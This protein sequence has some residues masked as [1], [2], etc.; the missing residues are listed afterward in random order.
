MQARPRVRATKTRTKKKI[1]WSRKKR[2]STQQPMGSA[3]AKPEEGIKGTHT[4]QCPLLI[5]CTAMT[6][7][8]EEKIERNTL[9][10]V[11]TKRENQRKEKKM[12]MRM[13]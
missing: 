3:A 10:W 11:L 9:K 12:K 7:K 8:F 6:P 1:T 13:A 5:N 2:Q 4:R